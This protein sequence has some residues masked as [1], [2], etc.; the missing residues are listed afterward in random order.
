MEANVFT[1][2]IDD[3]LQKS[4]DGKADAIQISFKEETDMKLDFFGTGLTHLTEEKSSKTLCMAK[5]IT[6]VNR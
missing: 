5:S 6:S 1:K 3:L 4:D 2:P